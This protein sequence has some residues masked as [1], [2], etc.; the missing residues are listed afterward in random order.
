MVGKIFDAQH[1]YVLAWRIMAAGALVG[2]A[3]VYS[4]SSASPEV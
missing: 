3:A 1:S 4:V 2:A